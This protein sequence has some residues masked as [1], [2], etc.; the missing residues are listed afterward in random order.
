MDHAYGQTAACGGRR[1]SPRPARRL[2][3]FLRTTTF[4]WTLAA[5]AAFA[6]CIA[7]MFGLVYWQTSGYATAMVDRLDA[8]EANTIKA[9]TP[10][11]AVEELNQHLRVDPLR[12]K[13]GGL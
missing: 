11:R 7:L 13:L 6:V 5:S 8:D 1:A 12:L 3:D 9:A 4:R 2:P 10:A